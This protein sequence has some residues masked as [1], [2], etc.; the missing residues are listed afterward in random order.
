MYLAGIET[1][2]KVTERGLS[3]DATANDEVKS[4]TWSLVIAMGMSGTEAL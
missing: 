1:V 4:M 2:S 3:I